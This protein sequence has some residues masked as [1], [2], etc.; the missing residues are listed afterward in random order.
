[1]M[2]EVYYMEKIPW[3]LNR[4]DLCLCPRPVSETG[5]DSRIFSSIEWYLQRP[6]AEWSFPGSIGDSSQINF[7]A[8]I[9]LRLIAET[10]QSWA[11]A[12]RA[13]VPRRLQSLCQSRDQLVSLRR[14]IP[15]G[16][17]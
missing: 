13:Q 10:D 4:G 7:P 11:I 2:L 8:S 15:P 1:M 12:L 5:V 16:T 3:Y 17:R 14:T 9:A 6:I